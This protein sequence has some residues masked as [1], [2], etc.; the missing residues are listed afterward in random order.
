[1]GT[2]NAAAAT[3]QLQVV[4][5]HGPGRLLLQLHAAHALLGEEPLF[6]RHNQGRRIGEGDEAQGDG[7]GFR[8]T[9][10]CRLGRRGRLGRQATQQG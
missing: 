3:A 7:A 9:G 8:L 10:G 2:I 5:G 6:L 1:M 4:T